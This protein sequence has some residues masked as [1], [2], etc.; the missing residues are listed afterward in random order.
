MSYE[1]PYHGPHAVFSRDELKAIKAAILMHTVADVS[2]HLES[3]DSALK[4]ID[5]ALKSHPDFL[6]PAK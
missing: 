6:K 4:K 3:V 1:Q 5:A 2:S